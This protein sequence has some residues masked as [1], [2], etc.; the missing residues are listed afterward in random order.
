VH[1]EERMAEEVVATISSVLC[2]RGCYGCS[3][4]SDRARDRDVRVE[5]ADDL[6]RRPGCP[7]EALLLDLEPLER[8]SRDAVTAGFGASTQVEV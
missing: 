2:G 7:V 6:V 8:V 1:R 5:R 4:P 3:P